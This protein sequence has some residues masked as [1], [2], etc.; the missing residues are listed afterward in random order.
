MFYS[1]YLGLFAP[2]HSASKDSDEPNGN[3]DGGSSSKKNDDEAVIDE[4]DPQPATLDRETA[5][6]PPD[7]ETRATLHSNMAAC[8][9]KVRDNF[10]FCMRMHK[11]NI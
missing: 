3:T 4:D 8:Y 5:E 6:A 1:H 11:S 2:L 7:D 9:L 10:Q